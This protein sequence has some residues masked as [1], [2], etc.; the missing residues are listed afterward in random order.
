MAVQGI[1]GGSWKE[2]A[3]RPCLLVF[4]GETLDEDILQQLFITAVAEAEEQRT[5][6]GKDAVCPPQ[7]ELFLTQN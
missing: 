1:H 7:E 2:G 3:E 4:I 5:T 6:P